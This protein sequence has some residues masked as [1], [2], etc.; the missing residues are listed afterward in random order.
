ML[1]P[2]IPEIIAT[3]PFEPQATKGF[4]PGCDETAVIALSVWPQPRMALRIGTLSS[5]PGLPAQALRSSEGP[6]RS[7]M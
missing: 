1:E 5:V 3:C 7:I 6:R 2:T 4:Q